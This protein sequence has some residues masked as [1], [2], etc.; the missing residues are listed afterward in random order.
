MGFIIGLL[1]FVGF[2]F[3][4]VA[5]I[6]A[7]CILIGFMC[8]NDKDGAGIKVGLIAAVVATVFGY[9]GYFIREY[10]TR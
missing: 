9:G 6:A 4:I 1:N 3:Y 10:P 8:N 7:F 2:L 5:A